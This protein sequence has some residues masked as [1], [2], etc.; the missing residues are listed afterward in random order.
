M[1]ILT[2]RGGLVLVLVLAALP[3]VAWYRRHQ[4]VLPPDA[5]S[6]LTVAREW[7]GEPAPD[8]EWDDRTQL[9]AGND[10]AR[11]PGYPLFLDLVFALRG[12]S[13]TDQA[14]LEG[15]RQVLADHEGSAARANHLRRLQTDENVRAVQAAQ[16]VLAVIAAGFAF[17]ILVQWTGS[18]AV[19]V[20]GSVAAVGWNPVWIVTFEPSV[21]T[22]TLAGVLILISVWLAG[23][24]SKPALYGAL[25]AA[26]GAANVAVRPAALFAAAPVTAYLLWRE[27]HHLYAALSIA[28][29]PVLVIAAP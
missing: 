15:P 29:P 11:T 20:A 5:Y 23:M 17:L 18:V 26:L 19:S 2:L 8:Y 13:P 16:H 21:M 22:E 25:A 27:R 12:H 3:R 10:A 24:S 1:P 4:P 28:I 7:R 9:P 6:Y 14:A